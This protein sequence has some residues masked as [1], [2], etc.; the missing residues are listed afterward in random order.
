MFDFLMLLPFVLYG[1][2]MDGGA[3][4]SPETDDW[5]DGEKQVEDDTKRKTSA[6]VRTVDF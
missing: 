6:T 2:I 4:N 3:E 5:K 1:G